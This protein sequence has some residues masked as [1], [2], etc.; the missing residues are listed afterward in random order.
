[1]HLPSVG[2]GNT[3]ENTQETASLINLN[4]T[5]TELLGIFLKHSW[6]V[7]QSEV[8]N[9]AKAK[10]LFTGQ[11]IESI[12]DSCYEHIDDLLIEEDADYFVINEV[13]YKTIFS[14]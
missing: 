6:S 4:T 1:I 10:G 11:L 9:F 12:N 13:Y 7:P 14:K 2:M 5:Q 8:N 3:I